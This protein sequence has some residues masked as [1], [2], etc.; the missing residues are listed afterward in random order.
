MRSVRSEGREHVWQH[1]TPGLMSASQNQGMTTGCLRERR[2][3]AGLTIVECSEAEGAI[4][5]E[6]LRYALIKDALSSHRI[7]A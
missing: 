6:T 2:L 4:R 3:M 5:Q 1:S 7:I